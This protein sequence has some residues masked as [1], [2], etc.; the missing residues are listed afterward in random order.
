MYQTKQCDHMSIYEAGAKD[1][2]KRIVVKDVSANYKVQQLT[3]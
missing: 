1:E 2:K 3:C